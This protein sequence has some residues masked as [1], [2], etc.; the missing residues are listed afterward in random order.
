[1][2]DVIGDC[3]EFN[4]GYSPDPRFSRSC[5]YH[6]VRW[7]ALRSVSRKNLTLSLVGAY[8]VGR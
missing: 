5:V 2:M 3:P 4:F 8:F 1:M 6:F 7:C